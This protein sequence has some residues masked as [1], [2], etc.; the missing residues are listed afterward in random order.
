MAKATFQTLKAQKMSY[1]TGK[2]KNL[3]NLCVMNLNKLNTEKM[4]NICNRLKACNRFLSV[5]T[6]IAQ[7]IF[8]FECR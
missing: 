8:A 1:K 6:R 3:K 5:D 2:I 7:I 4:K